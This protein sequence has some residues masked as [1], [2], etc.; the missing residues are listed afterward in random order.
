[1][2]AVSGAGRGR[3]GPADGA[4]RVADGCPDGVPGRAI[5]W[6]SRTSRRRVVTARGGFVPKSARFVPRAPDSSLPMPDSSHYG[7]CGLTVFSCLVKNPGVWWCAWT[8]IH[9]R[10]HKRRL[11]H[12][13]VSQLVEGY[14]A[15]AHRDGRWAVLFSVCDGHHGDEHEP[16]TPGCPARVAI[17]R[18]GSRRDHELRHPSRV[19]QAFDGHGWAGPRGLCG[20]LP[21][22][23]I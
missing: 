2:P 4:E 13:K 11:A 6:D 12:E 19:V 3:C 16:A 15:R 14:C 17:R 23:W 22:Q 7:F 20:G 5:A 9:T 18:W 1:M 10:T 8:V 21:D